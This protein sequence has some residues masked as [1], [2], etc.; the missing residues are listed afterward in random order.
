[1]N[2]WFSQILILAR[3]V[4]FLLKVGLA[5]FVSLWRLTLPLLLIG[6]G[7][8]FVK[9]YFSMGQLSKSPDADRLRKDRGGVIEICPHCHQE[10]GSCSKCR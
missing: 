3:G 10:V 1:M 6:G 5:M 4:V 2:S 7:I 8:Y 9:K